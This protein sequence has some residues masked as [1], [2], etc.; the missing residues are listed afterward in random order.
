[1]YSTQPTYSYV[2]THTH[3]HI[4]IHTN[5]DMYM[6]RKE[7]KVSRLKYE[8]MNLTK[9]ALLGRT[10]NIRSNLRDRDR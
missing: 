4:H 2:H 6:E 9:N 3:T 7:T 5:I 1:M 8:Y 10:Y